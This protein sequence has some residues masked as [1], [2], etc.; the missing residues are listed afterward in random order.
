MADD[1]I[2]LLDRF[3]QRAVFLGEGEHPHGKTRDQQR[4]E[5]QSGAHE[6]GLEV[7]AEDLL[8]GDL[9]RTAWRAAAQKRMQPMA[10]RLFHGKPFQ[11]QRIPAALQKAGIGPMDDTG[12][13]QRLLFFRQGEADG[14]A[15]T[16]P[17]G[18]VSEQAGAPFAQIGETAVARDEVIGG[19]ILRAAKTLNADRRPS[20]LHGCAL[21]RLGLLDVLGD[22]GTYG[23]RQ[24]QELATTVKSREAVP[25]LMLPHDA[26]LGL[27]RLRLPRQT[28]NEAQRVLRELPIRLQSDA[29][30]AEVTGRSCEERLLLIPIHQFD[31]RI[32]KMHARHPPTLPEGLQRAER[33]LQVLKDALEGLLTLD[34]SGQLLL[35]KSQLLLK[36]L[37]TLPLLPEVPVGFIAFARRRL[38]ARRRLLQAA[39]VGFQVVD[40]RPGFAEIPLAFFPLLAE[41][42]GFLRPLRELRF[43]LA[44]LRSGVRQL[45][46]QLARL[47]ALFA[48]I[49][50]RLLD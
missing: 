3:A 37:G 45:A 34:G 23:I 13:G 48:Q 15:S 29:T 47:G 41:G 9:Q 50:A 46:L 35:G 8:T 1:G 7:E 20:L 22:A 11:P 26:R 38:Q 5:H 14:E 24:L 49:P 21:R 12:G 40:A 32:G 30:A 43:P 18:F 36:R 28:Q 27:N 25:R 2:A 39:Q 16:H 10:R 31:L 4:A 33:A 19:T 42:G 6:E 17:M 44:Q